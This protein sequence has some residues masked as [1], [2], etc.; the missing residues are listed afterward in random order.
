VR[1]RIRA[2]CRILRG[3]GVIYGCALALPEDGR[4]VYVASLKGGTVSIIDNGFGPY[5][6]GAVGEVAVI[7]YET[8]LVYPLVADGRV[9]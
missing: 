8:G 3:R 1:R 9:P 6:D 5:I 2:A 4:K 7:D